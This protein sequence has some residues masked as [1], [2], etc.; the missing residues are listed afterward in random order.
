MRLSSLSVRMVVLAALIAT[1]EA[2]KSSPQVTQGYG[3]LD[4][5]PICG[6]ASM[7]P[8]LPATLG[9]PSVVPGYGS[10]SGT[11][12]RAGATYGIGGATVVLSSTEIMRPGAFRRTT[13]QA[14]GFAFDSLAPGGYRLIVHAALERPDSAHV[15][16]AA[17]QVDTVRFVLSARGGCGR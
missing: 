6:T 14:G 16:V 5:D 11:V 13:D 9:A 10:I 7:E 8:R 2:C 4:F 17:E 15:V 12:S 1:P 3:L